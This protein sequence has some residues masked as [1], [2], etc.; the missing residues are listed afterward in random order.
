MA[1]N[2][3]RG[4]LRQASGGTMALLAGA[5]LTRAAVATGELDSFIKAEMRARRIPGLAACIIKSGKVAWSKGY[6]WADVKRRVAMDPASTIQNIGSIS[7][8][9]TATAAMQLWEKG[10]FDLEDDVNRHLPFA[11]RNPAHPGTPVTVRQLL[12]HRSSIADSPAYG[13]SYACGDPGAS[14]EEWVRGY[15]TPGGRHYR[16]DANFHAWKPGEKHHYSNMGFGLLGYL[17]ERVS[18]EPFHEY[19]QRHIAEP[20]KMTASGWML[21]DVDA[22]SHAVPYVPV[23][24]GKVE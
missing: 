20:L 22:K 9:V 15:F 6:G 8:T 3:R 10:K 24:D 7:K 2:T 21:A 13:S 5:R 23:D 14:L 12:T 11:V 19:T 17:V 18:G 4:F 16:E 1:G